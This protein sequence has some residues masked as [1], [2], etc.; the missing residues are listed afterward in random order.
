MQ[1]TGFEYQSVT[2]IQ[3]IDGTSQISLDSVLCAKDSA[4]WEHNTFSDVLSN[5]STEKAFEGLSAW[6]NTRT[7]GVMLENLFTLCH[8][9]M[10]KVLDYL[11]IPFS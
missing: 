3:K 4:V 11:V 6:P 5:A 8:T 2:K 9:F 7:L 1:I 10:L